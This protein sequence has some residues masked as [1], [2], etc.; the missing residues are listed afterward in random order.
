LTERFVGRV[1]GVRSG[2]ISFFGL[3][4]LNDLRQEAEFAAGL[5][6]G[7]VLTAAWAAAIAFAYG[8]CRLSLPQSASLCVAF[9]C[10]F[11]PA[12]LNFTPGKDPAQLLFVLAI[13]YGWMKSF[14]SGR[15]RWAFVSGV[16][17][18][19]GSMVGL[20]HLW[21]AAIAAG[22]TLWHAARRR[23]VRPWVVGCFAPAGVGFAMVAGLAYL[24]LDWNLPRTIYRVAVR[25][26]EIQL[27]IITDPLYWTLV[28]LPMFLLFVGPLFWVE[29][30]AVRRDERDETASLGGAL[31]ACTAA[32]MAYSYF[33]ANNSETPRLWIPFIPPLLLSMAL[34][35]SAFRGATPPVR[36][37]H[38]LLIALQLSITLAHWC[39]MDSR[40]SEWRIFTTGR[41]WD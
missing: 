28:G 8:L 19:A 38:L 36:K 6:F 40:E 20:I 27:P 10:V 15:K 23:T 32:V 2:L 14:I 21:I 17:L 37:F 29:T 31:L 35:R 13:L 12:T 4:E 26:G 30:A 24:A 33:L 41:M 11:N 39:L 5:L 1:E 18:A 9:A 34:R 25:F 16:V 22:A 3:E 7:L